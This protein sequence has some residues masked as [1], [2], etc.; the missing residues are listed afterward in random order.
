M[1]SNPIK[2][3]TFRPIASIAL[4]M[5]LLNLHTL[6]AQEVSPGGVKSISTWYTTFV[7]NDTVFWMDH[8]QTDTLKPAF[9]GKPQ[10]INGHPAL[11][12]SQAN[13][14]FQHQITTE[15]L[16]AFTFFSVVQPIDTAKEQCIWSVE[17]DTAANLVLTTSRMA[18]VQAYQYMNFGLSA[19]TVPQIITY[20]QKKQADTTQ[21]ATYRIRMGLK[22][23]SSKIPV[24]AFKGLIPEMV[25]CDKTLSL[26]ERIKVESYLALKYGISLGQTIQTPYLSAAGDTIWN[27]D[28]NS[29]YGCN[30]AGVGRDDRS[31]LNQL[32]STSSNAPNLL[33]ITFS[34]TLPDNAF[35]VWGD[36][37]AALQMV[38]QGQKTSRLARAWKVQ[39]THLPANAQSTINFNPNLIDQ[40]NP[41]ETDDRYWLALS[42]NESFDVRATTFTKAHAANGNNGIQHFSVPSGSAQEP[43]LWF[44]VVAAPPFFAKTTITPANCRTNTQAAIATRLAGGVAPYNLLLV[45]TN[46]GNPT[47]KSETSD[48]LAIWTNVPVGTYQL[49]ASDKNGLSFAQDIRVTNGDFIPNLI[50]GEYELQQGQQLTIDASGQMPTGLFYN[51]TKDDVVL[52]EKP[53]VAIENDGTYLL[54]VY[55]GKGCS[56]ICSINVIGKTANIIDQVSLT[57]NPTV[58]NRFL[59]R[60]AL[61]RVADIDI[62]ISELNGNILKNEHLTGDSFYRY[63]GFVA[64]TG[65][66]L[67]TIKSGNYSKSVKLIVK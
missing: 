35:F 49:I 4:S 30:I 13:S 1:F 31:G 20:Q 48:S 44:T 33:S 66:Y 34:D 24:S 2:N 36:N 14:Q 11:L 67:I 16:N 10:F 28:Q 55:D 60:V 40:M 12:F 3:M 9:I 8:Q 37:G 17:S 22:P 38:D 29:S 43:Y 26:T 50:F 21:Q 63:Q 39:S 25:I 59:L 65:T 42:N 19:S 56:S 52:S 54:E 58:D 46:D 27:P 6:L 15:K 45:N 5:L 62:Q 32:T 18:D 57:P 7:Q 41:I 61:N 64:H 53:E 23:L 47:I 51:W